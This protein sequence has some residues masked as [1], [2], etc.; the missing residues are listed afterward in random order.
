MDFHLYYAF[1]RSSFILLS[2]ISFSRFAII[3]YVVFPDYCI[4]AVYV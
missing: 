4:A 3:F 1:V 2:H